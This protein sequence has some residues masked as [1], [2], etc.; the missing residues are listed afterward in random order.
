VTAGPRRDLATPPPLRTAKQH[1]PATTTAVLPAARCPDRPMDHT[2][3]APR[4]PDPP[5]SL[6]PVRAEHRQPQPQRRMRRG[7]GP[8]GCGLQARPR[9]SG[10]QANAGRPSGG[11]FARA[12]RPA[13]CLGHPSHSSSQQCHISVPAPPTAPARSTLRAGRGGFV[14][15]SVVASTARGACGV[16]R[17]TV[18]GTLHCWRPIRQT[19]ALLSVHTYQLTAGRNWSGY[20]CNR[21]A[22]RAVQRVHPL[23]NPSLEMGLDSWRVPWRLPGLLEMNQPCIASAAV[24]AAA[25]AAAP[26]A[27]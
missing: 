2:P 11:P 15:D 14:R 19:L 23:L 26:A 18:L 20:A 5:V 27:P 13:R 6:G 9:R 1:G 22:G 7:G 3:C 24:P 8:A 4:T 25:A 21:G 12:G 10:A 17:C 16:D